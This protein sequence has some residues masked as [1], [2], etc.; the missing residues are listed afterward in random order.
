[1]GWQGTVLLRVDVKADGT[2][3]E[4]TVRRSS[5]HAILDEAALTAVKGW[6]FAPPTDGGFSMSTVVDVPV[7]FDLQEYLEHPDGGPG[8]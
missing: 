6:R 4:V 3:G 2:V 1:M 8:S 7:R 5:G